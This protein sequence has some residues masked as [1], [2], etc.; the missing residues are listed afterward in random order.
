MQTVEQIEQASVDLSDY[1]KERGK[2]TPNLTHGA[3]QMLLGAQ[4]L[5]QARGRF[6][7]ISELTLE[8]GDGLTLTP[9]IAVL[10]KRQID[11]GREPAR[12]R[13]FPLLV[14]EILS[15]SQGYQSVVEK[16]DAYFAHGV[17]SVWQ[18]NPALRAIAIY[19]PGNNEPEIIQHG[20]AKDLSTG[21]TARLDEI[22]A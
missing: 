17:K 13:D 21:L 3:I 8:F 2:P 7:V 1:E 18:V 16:I 4:L 19:H 20:E 10:A 14:V 22:F 15:P 9:D 12:C 6:L 11:W 5:A